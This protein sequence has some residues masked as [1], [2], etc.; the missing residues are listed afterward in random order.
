[1]KY[2]EWKIPCCGTEVD[3]ALVEAGY[4]PLLSALLKKRGIN[5]PEAARAFL[6]GG[7][8]LLGDPM[9]LEDMDRA[10]ARLRLA[11]ERHEVVA[12][13]GDYDV[14]G[15]TSACL[16]TSY[17][18]SRGLNCLP[19]IPSRLG[20]GYGLNS[21]ALDTIK[22][23]G[24]S[25][26]ITVDCG[27]TAV[28]E[29]EH[30]RSLGLDLIITDHHECGSHELPQ[31]YAVV[32]P[33]RPDCPYPNK[34]LAGVGVAFKLLCAVDGDAGALLDE[35]ADLVAAGTV[36]DVMPLTD[37]NRYLV[38]RGLAKLNSD[39]R[40]GVEA[41][42]SE[43]GGKIKRLNATTVGFTIAPRI[44]AAGRLGNAALGARLLLSRTYDEAL[45]LAKELCRLNR[46][47][48]ELEQEIW[49]EAHEL[50]RR[51]PPTEPIVLASESWHQGVIGIAASRLAE[52]YGLP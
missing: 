10:A 23:A 22:A 49:V 20:E 16:V 7:Q 29:A 31:A 25:L 24:A 50:L 21:A 28:Q 11:I 6:S 9:L 1:M 26:V 46:E 48:Q 38:R 39:P 17:L 13:F 33:K 34:S 18:R 44:N 8:E 2:S 51:S 19:Y 41:L 42:L 30:A 12:V 14:D 35:Y 40:P 5:T 36:A 4:T 45:P 43:C 37:E 3:E 15:I 47:R 32:D 27:I 52:E